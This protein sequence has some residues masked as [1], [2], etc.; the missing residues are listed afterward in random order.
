MNPYKIEI[1]KISMKYSLSS[2][3]SK[4][5]YNFNKNGYENHFE[6]N[7]KTD[8]NITIK[9]NYCYLSNIYYS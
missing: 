1:I 3:I 4:I 9:L 2:D 6:T 5:I 7:L 8:Y